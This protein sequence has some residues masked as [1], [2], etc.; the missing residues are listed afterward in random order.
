MKSN[1]N[2][3]STLA[4]SSCFYRFG[5]MKS[6]FC[7]ILCTIALNTQAQESV[8]TSGA[9]ASGAGG[10]ADFSV[11]QTF[12]YAFG[13]Q[14]S[15]Q[16]GV[17]HVYTQDIVTQSLQALS[18]NYTLL[19]NPANSLITITSRNQE[20]IQSISI[21]DTAGRLCTKIQLNQSN[22]SINISNLSNGF[23]FIHISPLGG[24][25]QIARFIKQD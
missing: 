2:F 17:Q 19:P 16:D 23:Y 12:V 5:K 14:T 7:F 1:C 18:N 22:P 3:Q 11:G 10:I 20:Q 4:A 15:Q 21:Y 9:T 13:N 8:N 6:L 25:R 24:S